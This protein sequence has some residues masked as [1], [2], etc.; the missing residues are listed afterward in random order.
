VSMLF[1]KFSEK[2]HPLT[3]CDLFPVK[4]VLKS[5]FCQPF[6]MQGVVLLGIFLVQLPFISDPAV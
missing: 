3:K 2:G 1:D 6:V 5:Q 4:T